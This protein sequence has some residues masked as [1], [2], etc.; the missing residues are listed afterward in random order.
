MRGSLVLLVC[1]MAAGALADVYMHNPR[2]SNNRLHGAGTN[3]DNQNRLF[4]SQNNAKGGYNQ[5]YMYYYTGS[6]MTIEWTNQHGAGLHPFL[7]SELVL[8]YM[9]DDSSPDV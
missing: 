2:G 4:D 9:C 1:L 5:G 7:R 3:A 8:Q 6:Q